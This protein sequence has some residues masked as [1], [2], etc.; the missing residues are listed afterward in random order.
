MKKIPVVLLAMALMAAGNAASLKVT[1]ANKLGFDRNKEIVSVN[2]A[3]VKQKLGSKSFIVTD[4]QG[5]QL[6]YQITADK[7]N[8][9]FPATVKANALSVY[10]IK[11]G[12]PEKFDAKTFGRFVPERKDDFAWENDRIAFRMYGPKLTPENPSNGVDVWLKKT[13]KLIVDKFYYNDLQLHQPYHV[14]HGEGLD[15]YK[16]GHALGAGGIA[17]YT[18][19]TLWV[20]NRYD[21]WKVIENGPLRTTFQ[22]F[23]DSVKVGK[24]WIGEV[25]TVSI[26][27]GSQLNKAV[28]TYSGKIPVGMKVATGLFLHDGKGV[29]KSDAKAGYIGYGEVATSDDGVPAGR[30]YVG[31]VLPAGRMLAAKRQGAHL[32]ALAGYVP[33]SKFVYYFGAGWNQW[34]F[35]DDQS[36]FDYLNNFALRLKQPLQ[37]TLK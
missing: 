34:G 12:T 1:V 5:Q 18:D 36:W 27:A 2:L 9:I 35:P 33:G 20:G 26:D 7:K 14:D 10:E 25:Y 37:V 8:V 16:V 23:Y 29:G 31:A 11:P 22:L 19:T 3:I 28:V 21:R 13:D 4:A 15:C 32:L 30:N 17:P 6:P 24:S